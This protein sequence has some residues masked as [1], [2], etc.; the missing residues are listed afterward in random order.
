MGRIYQVDYERAF[1]LCAEL[2][3][4]LEELEGEAL[5]LQRIVEPIEA[6]WLPHGAVARAY[7]ESLSHRIRGDLSQSRGEVA[8]LRQALHALKALEEEQARR[9]RAAR[10]L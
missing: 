5:A 2:E 7:G 3:R 8:T 9:M 1:A 6:Q 4:L 10:G